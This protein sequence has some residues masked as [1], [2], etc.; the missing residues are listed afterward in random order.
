MMNIALILA[1]GSG[2]RMGSAVP[3]QFLP[4]AG[5]EVILRTL[6]A[7]ESHSQIDAI[8]VVCGEAWL[9]HME[10]LVVKAGLQKVR[11]ILPGGG[12]RRESSFLGLLALEEECSPEDIVLIHD[13][14]RPLVSERMISD[15][16]ACL[17]RGGGA[18]Y[19]RHTSITACPNCTSLTA[20]TVAIPAR[21]TI[22]VSADGK[23]ADRVPERSTLYAVQTPQAFRLGVIL[24]G[25]RRCPAEQAVTDDAGILLAQGVEVRLVDGEVRN[26]KITSAEDMEIAEALLR[27]GTASGENEAKAEV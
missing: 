18:A 1:G 2:T 22:L 12:T 6:D 10:A 24:E 16:I 14:A 27:R 8:W 25:H 15:C 23:R 7:F 5:R 19:P 17:Q 11:G 13:A 20:C 3:K 9:S 21:D 4:L 26:L